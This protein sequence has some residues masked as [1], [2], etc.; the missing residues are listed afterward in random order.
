MSRSRRER[1]EAALRA[2]GLSVAPVAGDGNCLFRAVAAQLYGDEGAH[3]VVRAAATDLMAVDRDFFAGFVSEPWP[4]YLARMRRLG[5]W[6]DDLEVQAISDVS[7]RGVEIWGWSALAGAARLRAFASQ[8][9]RA[10][11]PP[12]VRLSFFLGGHYDSLRGAGAPAALL[13]GP[14]GDAEAAF[15]E[16]VQAAVTKVDAAKHRRRAA[17]VKQRA[18]PR[19]GGVKAAPARSAA[20]ATRTRM[21][22]TR[23]KD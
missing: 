19:A 12:P 16:R 1:Y 7:G 18:P 2:R 5:T 15:A 4:P 6:G 3:G 23:D 8:R 9:P 20:R 22:R 11:A 21:R 17:K 10:G 13:P 14:P